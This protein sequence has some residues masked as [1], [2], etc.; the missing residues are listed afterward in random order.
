MPRFHFLAGC[1]LLFRKVFVV[2]AKRGITNCTSQLSAGPPPEPRPSCPRSQGR[3]ADGETPPPSGSAT[4]LHFPDSLA[5]SQSPHFP[6]IEYASCTLNSRQ[7]L[8]YGHDPTGPAPLPTPCP[9]SRLSPPPAQPIRTAPSTEALRRV[10]PV[11]SSWMR[12]A[13]TR[14]NPSSKR[15]SP[16]ALQPHS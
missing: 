11:A 14:I 6:T 12:P 1:N 7:L 3:P 9:R 15:A 5:V 16:A 4:P 13:F 8:C 2:P 10:S